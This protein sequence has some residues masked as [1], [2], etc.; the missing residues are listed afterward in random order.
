VQSGQLTNREVG[1]LERG[2]ARDSRLQANAA[3]DGRVGPR[4]SRR[5]QRAENVQSKRIFKEKHDA[6]TK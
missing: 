1:K 5:L 6:Q 3:A 2:Q 4:E